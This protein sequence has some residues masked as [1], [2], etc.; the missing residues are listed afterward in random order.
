MMMS[1]V[2][3]LIYLAAVSNVSGLVPGGMYRIKRSTTAIENPQLSSVVKNHF[4]SKFH[5]L[6][7][8]S[9]HSDGLRGIN[10]FRFSRSK[11]K[12]YGE[13]NNSKS[14]LSLT[15]VSNVLSLDRAMLPKSASILFKL[16]G[17]FG[18][19]NGI[20]SYLVGTILASTIIKLLLVLFRGSSEESD[21]ERPSSL[22]GIIWSKIVNAV[23]SIRS[24]ETSSVEEA[25]LDLNKW[26]ACKLQVFSSTIY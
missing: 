4:H 22:G 10:L 24:S 12:I 21:V 9:A 14:K 5:R 6:P 1:K 13:C 11:T 17:Y 19:L 7:I 25:A 16:I 3:V 23:K 15:A 8:S 20:L 26:N 2:K 18:G